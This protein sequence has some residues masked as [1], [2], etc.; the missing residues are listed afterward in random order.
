MAVGDTVTVRF[1]VHATDQIPANATVRHVDQ[2]T[3]A[4]LDAFLRLLDGETVPASALEDGQVIV[5][6]DYYRVETA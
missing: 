1:R 4:E 6:T 3:D 5:F 2:L